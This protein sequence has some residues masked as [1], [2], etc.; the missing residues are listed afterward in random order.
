MAHF[1]TEKLLHVQCLIIF[2]VRLE[3]INASFLLFRGGILTVCTPKFRPFYSIDLCILSSHVVEFA[4]NCIWT[5][6]M[7][8]SVLLHPDKP[9]WIKLLFHEKSNQHKFII[10]L[11]KIPF[12]CW[13]HSVTAVYTSSMKGGCVLKELI[14]HTV[15]K[16]TLKGLV[17]T[18]HLI[19]WYITAFSFFLF[20]YV[21]G[22]MFAL[23]NQILMQETQTQPKPSKQNSSAF[24][25]NDRLF[26]FPP[27]R[28][29]LFLFEGSLQSLNLLKYFTWFWVMGQ[30]TERIFFRVC[31][32]RLPFVC[33]R[34]NHSPFL[35]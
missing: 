7:M 23:I 11:K 9:V 28:I 33:R 16:I 14:V 5:L 21:C 35:E 32:H 27:P 1:S 13:A 25:S 15:T 19:S 20:F 22:W 12:L 2:W 17:T 18:F 29:C 26:L 10:S 30:F 31:C 8:C 34:L 3:H 4:F 6:W 24:Q